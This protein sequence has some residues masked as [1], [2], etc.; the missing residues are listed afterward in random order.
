M[1]RCAYAVMGRFV[2]FMIQLSPAHAVN[3]ITM[4]RHLELTSMQVMVMQ[5]VRLPTT[6]CM[7]KRI[8]NS[9]TDYSDDSLRLSPSTADLGFDSS[10]SKVVR[11]YGF[12][13]K[14]MPSDDSARFPLHSDAA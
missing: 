2:A 12:E 11:C 10:G 6:M 7:K 14:A 9:Y 13:S 4:K 8:A 3:M 1:Q 5:F